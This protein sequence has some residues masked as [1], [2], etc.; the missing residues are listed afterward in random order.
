MDWLCVNL[1]LFL[2]N[3]S[4]QLILKGF[5]VFSFSVAILRRVDVTTVG[6]K[7]QVARSQLAVRYL[8]LGTMIP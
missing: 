7:W 4:N 6:V 3:S 5:S 2:D 8:L 1:E